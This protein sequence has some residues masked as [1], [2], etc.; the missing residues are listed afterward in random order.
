[1]ETG[2]GDVQGGDSPP[3][4]PLPGH[5][6]AR[7]SPGRPLDIAATGPS[8]RSDSSSSS[9]TDDWGNGDRISSVAPVF[10]ELLAQV[11]R[12]DL[13]G[14]LT[15]PSGRGG[16]EAA[17]PKRR[18]TMTP[19]ELRPPLPRVL[20]STCPPRRAPQ[21]AEVPRATPLSPPSTVRPSPSRPQCCPGLRARGASRGAAGPSTGGRLHLLRRRRSSLPPPGAL[22]TRG[23]RTPPRA[24][25]PSLSRRRRA[26]SGRLRS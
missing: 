15:P 12:L 18:A 14:V 23:A 8:G 20:T 22:T 21:T 26:V 17:P 7:T 16:E 19:S 6:V 25:T 24:T 9:S 2:E 13:T 5:P 3:R 10:P 1:M 11:P 4:H